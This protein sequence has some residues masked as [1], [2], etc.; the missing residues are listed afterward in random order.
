[1]ASDNPYDILGVDKNASQED[2]KK[3]FKDKAKNTHPDRGGNEE[4]FKKIAEA[5]M[6]LSDPERRK[7]YDQTGSTKNHRPSFEQRLVDHLDKAIVAAIENCEISMIKKFN[8]VTEIINSNK[9][10]ISKFNKEINNIT[11]KKQTLE[12]FVRRLSKK[13]KGSSDLLKASISNR[14]QMMDLTIDNIRQEIDFLENVEKFLKEY[15]Y[16]VDKE[17]KKEKN[18]SWYRV[19]G[20]LDDFMAKNFGNI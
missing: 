6:I 7:Y 16:R 15:E 3:A 19:E 12:E 5:N 1:M 8:I 17:E 14:M 4:E 9:Q 10:Q 13:D 18:E 2:I 11:R 20:T